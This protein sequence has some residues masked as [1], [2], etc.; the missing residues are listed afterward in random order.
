MGKK[1]FYTPNSRIRA[2]LRQLFLRSRERATA[3]KRDKYTCVK[4]GRKQSKAVGKEFKVQVH[5]KCGVDN[6]DKLFEAVRQYLLCD[7][8]LMETLCEDC[9]KEKTNDGKN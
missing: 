2:A 7:P 4:C 9:H 1:L 6:W 8:G 5:H 3:I